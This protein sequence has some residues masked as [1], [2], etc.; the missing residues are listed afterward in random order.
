MVLPVVLSMLCMQ[1]GIK[2]HW[3]KVGALVVC[4]FGKKVDS[5]IKLDALNLYHLSLGEVV[6]QYIFHNKLIFLAARLDIP[7]FTKNDLAIYRV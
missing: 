7:C 4:N 3:K 2:H 6:S 5:E 1:S